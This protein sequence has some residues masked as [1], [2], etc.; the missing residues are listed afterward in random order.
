M[1]KYAQLFTILI[2]LFLTM[3]GAYQWQN[4][5]LQS[6]YDYRSTI[7]DP[8]PPIRTNLTPQV[9][10]VILVIVSGLGFDSLQSLD[11]ATFNHLQASGASALLIASSPTYIQTTWTT[12]LSGADPTL[13]NAPPHDNI[14]EG[15][16]PIIINTLFDNVNQQGLGT[17]LAG[18]IWWQDMVESNSLSQGIFTTMDDAQGDKQI[19]DSLITLIE[20]EQLNFIML[21]FN[22]IYHA[23]QTY[24]GTETETYEIVSQQ[25]DHHL[26]TL[27]GL[28]DPNRTVLII[29]ADHGH[30]DIGGY[31]GHDLDVVRLPFIMMG[32]HIIPNNYSDIS[33]HDIAPTIALLLGIDF[34]S[35]NQGRPLVEMI[36]ISSED[37]ALAWLSMATQRTRLAETYL[38]SLDYP[39]PNREELYKAEVFLGNG[40]YAGASELAQLVIEKTDLSM[41]QASA[42]RLK[43][44]QILRLLLIIVIMIPLVFLTLIFRTELLGEAFVSAITTYIMYH[45]IY[46]AMNLPYSLSAI[47]SFNLFWLET[48]IRIVTSVIAGSIIF[49]MLLIFRQFTELAIIRRAIAEFLLLTT[50]ITMLPAMY[51]FWQHGLFITWHLPDTSIFFWHITSLIQTICFIFTGTIVSFIIIPLSNPLQNFLARR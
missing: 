14:A 37:K 24:G 15:I 35:R 18:H 28:I 21:H 12:L 48:M 17:A 11:L 25:I 10:R 49:V 23:V 8:I 30:I 46:W 9:E 4:S 42:V 3:L 13:N 34:P 5:L 22:Q 36:R 44:E 20:N 51:G 19:A 47:N 2:V 1:R 29:T 26:K 50:F 7:I 40:N 32:K 38:R 41:A 6:F 33:Q 43:R 27:V 45:A 16:P 39:P 31:G